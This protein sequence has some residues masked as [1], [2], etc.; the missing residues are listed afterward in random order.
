MKLGPKIDKVVVLAGNT[1]GFIGNRTLQ[2]YTGNAEFLME[3]GAAPEQVDRVAVAF[4]MPMGPAAM[5]DLAGLDVGLMVQQARRASLPSDERFSP[6][7]ERMVAAGRLGQKVGKGFYRYEGR[8]RFS[9]SEALEVI[10]SVARDLRIEQ[11]TFSDE[12]IRDRLFMPLV[13]EG[14]KELQD[15]T[16]KRAGD[17]DVAWVNGYGFPAYKG[18]PMY[19]GERVGLSKVC[20]MAEQLGK[21][22]GSRWKPSSLLVRLAQENQGWNDAVKNPNR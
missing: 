10:A 5:R 15:G 21:E 7:I 19:W 12:E 1:D 6:I 17:I 3:Q 2:Y 11:R 4:G 22:N 20:E 13:N 18:G 8:E 14:A 9:D 16:A